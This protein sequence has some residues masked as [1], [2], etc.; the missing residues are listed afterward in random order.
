MMK[1]TYTVENLGCANCAAKM[2]REI[3]ALPKVSEATLSFASRR[4]TVVSEE[5]LTETL[6]SVCES[7]EHGVV[8]R[9]EGT[10][11]EVT[12]EKKGFFEEWGKLAV[13]AVLFVLGFVFGTDTAEGIALFVLAYLVAGYEVLTV[14]GRDLVRGRLFD[15]N[16]LMAVATIGALIIGEYEEA[17]AIMLFYLFGEGMQKRAE[18]NSRRAVRDAS[19]MRPET[20]SLLDADGNRYSCRGGKG[21]RHLA[22]ACRRPYPARRGDR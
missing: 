6:Q 7:I 8:L 22:R 2:E 13:G 5:D 15:E 18:Q 14:A 3:C 9:A 4:L 19:L 20:V 12:Q 1:R 10:L 11:R 17:A 16:F 21:R